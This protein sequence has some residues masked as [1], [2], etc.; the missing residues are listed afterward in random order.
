[1]HYATIALLPSD[2]HPRIIGFGL[3]LAFQLAIGLIAWFLLE[4]KIRLRT[5]VTR[6]EQKLAL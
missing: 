6:K 2:E 5:F 3:P 1:L 4:R